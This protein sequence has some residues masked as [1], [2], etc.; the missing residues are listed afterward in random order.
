MITDVVMP[1][2]G[3]V[4]LAKRLRANQPDLRV[5]FVSGYTADKLDAQ[6]LEAEEAY[7]PKPFTPRDLLSRVRQLLDDVRPAA[8]R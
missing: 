2:L 7:L 5:L 6:G 1:R 4:Q 8:R 3:G